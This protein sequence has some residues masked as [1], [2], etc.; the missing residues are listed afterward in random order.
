MLWATLNQLEPLQQQLAKGLLVL[1]IVLLIG[2]VANWRRG[3]S[4]GNNPA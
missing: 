3:R 4:K 2:L 1:V